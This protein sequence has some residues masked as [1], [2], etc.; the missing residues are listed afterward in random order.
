MYDLMWFM[1]WKDLSGVK[2]INREPGKQAAVIYQPEVIMVFAGLEWIWSIA[3]SF[4][5]VL[6]VGLV[7]V[8]DMRV[9]G[10]WVIDDNSKNFGKCKDTKIS[11]REMVP[12]KCNIAL[13]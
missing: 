7:E 3:D 12:L 4:G 1:L 2:I 5:M 9:E 13:I 11:D 6:E 8:L 10:K